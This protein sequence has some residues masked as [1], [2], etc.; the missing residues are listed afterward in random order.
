ML[1]LGR[2]RAAEERDAECLREAGG[3]EA[4]RERQHRRGEDDAE[5]GRAVETAGAA[6]ERLEGEPLADEP[7]ERGERRDRDGSEQKQPRRPGHA[8]GEPAELLDIADVRAAKDTA[9]A[10]EEEAFECCV[11]DG[12]EE[13]G[14][15][16][17]G[18]EDAARALRAPQNHRQ[19][20]P[21]QDDPDVLDAVERE[22]A[23]EVVLLERVEHAKHG[24]DRARD[25]HRPSPGGRERRGVRGE[26]VEGEAQ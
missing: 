21:D 12:V 22:Q 2:S 6:E 20:H 11:V 13:C 16:R 3:G 5:P 15:E 26:E 14:G 9:R 25:E 23:L 7:V 1:G 8:P 24:R 4:S 18:R 10:E 19:P 17:D